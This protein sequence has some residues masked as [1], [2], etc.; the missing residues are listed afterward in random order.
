MFMLAGPQGATACRRQG[1]RG[2]AGVD[3]APGAQGPAGPQGIAGVADGAQVIL[4]GNAAQAGDFNITGTGT[5][6]SAVINGGQLRLGDQD[7]TAAAL[8][9]LVAGGNADALHTHAGAAN[10]WVQVTTWATPLSDIVA[11]IG[12]YPPVQYQWG[13]EVDRQVLVAGAVNASFTPVV[14]IAFSGLFD[15]P[16]GTAGFALK[17]DEFL[18]DESTVDDLVANPVFVT[19]HSRSMYQ[20]ARTCANVANGLYYAFWRKLPN[21]TTE[22]YDEGCG[23]LTFYVRRL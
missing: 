11:V 9:T 2:P 12:Q 13:I 19:A 22:R 20:P 5:I 23:G 7:L 10:P 6:A 3:G 14:P 18:A 17:S 8:Q 15:S 21:G 4:N 16:T 1:P